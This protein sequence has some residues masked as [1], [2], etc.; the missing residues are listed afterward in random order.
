MAGDTAL[1]GHR[2]P[3]SDGRRNYE[4]LLAEADS[5]FREQGTG[6]P[7]D[8]IARRAG[9]A[10]GTLYGHFPNRRA[11]VRALVAERNDDLFRRGEELLASAAPADALAAWM[12]AAVRHATVYR[13]LAAMLADGIG[14]EESE[15][16]ASCLRMAEYDES[17]TARARESGAIRAEVT[18]ADVSALISSAAWTAER[19]SI[20]QA[21]RLL[22]LA[23]T[24]LASQSGPSGPRRSPA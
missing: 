15:L 22:D 10:I 8:G 21:E 9:V 11:L 16:H 13:G 19:A 4:R 7:L 18:A 20:E 24:G 12:R 2:K 3:R 6:A 14:D 17:L 5:A 1:P 23:M